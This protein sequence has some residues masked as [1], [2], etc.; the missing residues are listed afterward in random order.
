MPQPQCVQPGDS[1]RLVEKPPLRLRS[2]RRPPGRVLHGSFPI[3]VGED[4]LDDIG[5]LYAR[6]DPHRSAASRAGLNVDPEYP[7]EAL[8]PGHAR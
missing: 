5:I 2:A 1:P 3:Q 4:F 7:L 6:D 8:R